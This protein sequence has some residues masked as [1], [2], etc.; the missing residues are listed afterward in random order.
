MTLILP[1][2]VI[3][4]SLDIMAEL[5]G[6][7]NSCNSLDDIFTLS[8]NDILESTL[9]CISLVILDSNDI[10]E[11]TEVF[12]DSPLFPPAGINL[13][14]NIALLKRVELNTAI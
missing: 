12:D 7:Y 4:T 8:P 1:F 6:L 11:C 14:L 5:I 13:V 3:P 9:E 10:V 2:T